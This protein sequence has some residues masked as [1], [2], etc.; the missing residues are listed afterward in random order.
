MNKIN[1]YTLFDLIKENDSNFKSKNYEFVANFLGKHSD[2]LKVIEKSNDKIESVTIYKDDVPV[3]TKC[4]DGTI[5]YG[6]RY[7][8]KNNLFYDGC[9]KRNVGE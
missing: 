2:K 3:K 9:L 1:Y 5:F 8:I 7:F 4:A 6:D